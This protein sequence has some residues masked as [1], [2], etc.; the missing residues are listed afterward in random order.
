MIAIVKIG[1]HQA[2]IEAGEQIEVD[3][4]D[5]EVGKTVQLETLLISSP[6]GSD[7]QIGA[8]ILGTTVEAKI[9]E[10][11]RGKKIRVY[12]MKQR[13]R[14][15]RTKGHRQDYTIVEI[16]KIGGKSAPKKAV[17]KKTSTTDDAPKKSSTK[18]DDLTKLEGVGKVYA[19]K[20]NNEG[21]FTFADVAKMTKKQ[22]DT[23]E[24]KY[25]FNGDFKDTIKDA[26]KLV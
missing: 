25:S 8:P 4:I 3:K 12:K 9:I 26:K 22:I 1:G 16:T 17:A 5:V 7:T 11:G 13:K 6:D 20:L 18:G 10:H 14:Y 2:I 19:G 15:R 21:I 24:E 23:M